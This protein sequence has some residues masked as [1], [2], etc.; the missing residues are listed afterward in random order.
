MYNVETAAYT[1]LEPTYFDVCHSHQPPANCPVC[2]KREDVEN[3]RVVEQ[4]TEPDGFAY[5]NYVYHLHDFVF[6][7]TDEGAC[8]IGQIVALKRVNARQPGHYKVAIHHLGRTGDIKERPSEILKD[9]V[10]VC[11]LCSSQLHW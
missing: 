2:L 1:D 3:K 4:L 10:S 11:N 8:D 5:M 7:R 6:M 9:E